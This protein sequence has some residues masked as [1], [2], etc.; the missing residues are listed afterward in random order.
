[1]SAARNIISGNGSEGFRTTDLGNRAPDNLIGTD[2][3]GTKP[4]GNTGSAVTLYRNGIVGD[5]NAASTNTIAFNGKSGVS[6]SNPSVSDISG[7]R[8][9]RNSIFSNAGLGIDLN[10]D[11]PT[12]NDTQDPDTGPNDLQNKPTLTS[13][14]TSEGTT[15]ARG[16]INSTP[17]AT[18]VIRYFSDPSGDE[19]KTLIGQKIV[20]T[21]ANGVTGFSPS[22]QPGRCPR[23]GTLRQRRLAPGST[24]PSSRHRVG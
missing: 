23:G 13:A 4:R 17:N 18:F 20:T 3:T 6:V 14:T 8:I 22:P 19:G 9:L 2:R 15:T 16:T 21:N 5:N 12:A 7:N 10:E 11:G 1:V 24:P